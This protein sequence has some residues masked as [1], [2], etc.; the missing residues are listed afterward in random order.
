MKKEFSVED[1]KFSLDI[2]T[3][4]VI[5]SVGIVKGTKIEVI[6]ECYVEHHERAMLDG[7]IHDISLVTK[8]VKSVIQ[9]LES[10][11]NIKLEKVNI[12]AAGRFLQ[13]VNSTAEIDLNKEDSI[14]NEWIKTLELKAIKEAEESIEKEVSGQL[15]CVG[16]SVINYYLNVEERICNRK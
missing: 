6:K 1:I 3:R 14:N 8:T 11:L 10:E 9:N 13:T 16:Y 15:Y 2:G 5:G 4:T 7:Q 12:A